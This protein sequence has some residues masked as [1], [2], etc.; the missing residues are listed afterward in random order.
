MKMK[1][2]NK[3]IKKQIVFV[4]HPNT[5]YTYKIARTL[6][7]TGRY[8]TVLITF[9]KVDKVFFNKAYDKIYEFELSHKANFKNIFTFIKRI[10]NKDFRKFIKDIRKLNPYL[11]Q[12]TGPDLFNTIVMFILKDKPK[13]YFAYDIWAFNGKS[14]KYKKN[15]IKEFCQNRFEKMSFKKADGILHKSVPKSLSLLD[16]LIN[17]PILAPGLLCLDEFVIP[18]KEKQKNKELNIVYAG[19]PEA[20]CAWRASFLKLIKNITSQKIHVHTYGPCLDSKDNKRFIEEAKNNSYF[21]MH[22]RINAEDLKKEISNY[23]YGFVH[24]FLN[25][26]RLDPRLKLTSLAHKMFD[27]IEVG[28]PIILGGSCKFVS[29]MIKENNIGV[30]VSYDDIKNLKQ[31]LNKI[32][33]KAMQKTIK[34]SQDKNKM[35]KKIKGFERFYELVVGNVNMRHKNDKS[36]CC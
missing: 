20:E 12:I 36:K 27:Y 22:D 7:L 23:D 1:M 16:Y 34:I 15:Q 10:L 4:E 3:I 14:F 13:I 32:D 19:G 33:Y 21:H 25:D 2:E 26:S 28:I 31:I 9:S 35:S 5:T 30:C 11:F 29:E 18:P 6:K 17:K 8:E 24:A